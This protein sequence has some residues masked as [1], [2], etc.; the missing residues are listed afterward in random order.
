MFL[1]R[2]ELDLKRRETLRA[3]TN[4]NFLHGA[5]EQSFEGG[6]GRRLWRVDRFD[7]LCFLLVLSGEQPDFTALAEQFGD[8]SEKGWEV[9]PY[10]DFI[11]NINAGRVWRFMLCANPVH[12]V[13]EGESGRGKIYAHI[14]ETHQKQWLLDRTDKNGFSLAD[15]N[16]SVIRS[17][18]AKFT[19]KTDAKK[20]VTI[21]R[22][23][24]EGVLTVTDPDSFRN[25][26]ANGIGRA[27]AYGCGLL[28]V[29]RL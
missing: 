26:L 4:P 23:V 11:N 22:A 18:W 28:T 24:Y 5:I 7:D 29:M 15:E 6:R 1:S 13:K 27:K 2:I 19:K 16:F 10:A 8:I 12:S 9:K 20:D 17:E 25:A 14:T 21:L 3:L